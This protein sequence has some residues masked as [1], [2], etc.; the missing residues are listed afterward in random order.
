M[1]LLLAIANKFGVEMASLEIA[2]KM[3][4]EHLRPGLNRKHEGH[5]QQEKN[6]NNAGNTEGCSKKRGMIHFKEV[7]VIRVILPVF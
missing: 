6:V 2:A 1:P 4:L 5:T 3:W 7:G